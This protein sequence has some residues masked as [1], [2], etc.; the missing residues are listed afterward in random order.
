MKHLYVMSKDFDELEKFHDELID[1]GF[2]DSRIH[3]WT[4]D[5]AEAENHRILAVNPFNKTNIVRMTI[6]GAILGVCLSSLLLVAHFYWGLSHPIGTV[7]FIFGALV[8][9][10]LSTWEGGLIGIHLANEKFKHLEEKIHSGNHLLIVD[11]ADTQESSIRKN[12]Q[13]HDFE[14][15]TA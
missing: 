6:R 15:V 1:E 10:G 11:Y 12:M 9:L 3:A 2:S 4:D 14:V 7:P 5:E 8:L 13:R